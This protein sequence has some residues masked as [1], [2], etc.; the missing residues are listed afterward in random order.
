V[1]RVRLRARGR[2]EIPRLFSAGAALAP[3]GSPAPL[4]H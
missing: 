4:A 3:Y 1:R 2:G